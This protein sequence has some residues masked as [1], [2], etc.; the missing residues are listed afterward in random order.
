MSP[1]SS[2]LRSSSR[3]VLVQDNLDFLPTL[4]AGDGVS[5]RSCPSADELGDP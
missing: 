2:P 5:S 4:L 3:P 1:S